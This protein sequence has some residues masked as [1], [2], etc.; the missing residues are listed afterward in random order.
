LLTASEQVLAALPPA[1]LAEAQLLRERHLAHYRQ[2]DPARAAQRSRL[3]QI[4]H[5]I[6][7]RVRGNG[8]VSGHQ[9]HVPE[10]RGK[11]VEGRPL[12]ETKELGAILKLLWLAQVR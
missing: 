1:L 8:H 9:H 5:A 6:Q 10:V 11:E 4:N 7:A 3:H 12:L 2:S